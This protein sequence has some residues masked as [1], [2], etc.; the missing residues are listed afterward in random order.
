[1][2]EAG[3]AEVDEATERAWLVRQIMYAKGVLRGRI[4]QYPD[5][6]R[7][8]VERRTT[9]TL[10]V[11]QRLHARDVANVRPRYGRRRAGAGL[12]AAGGRE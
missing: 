4:V 3:F 6:P 1:M 2:A 5:C 8:L 12:A 7:H 10:R 11:L 9:A